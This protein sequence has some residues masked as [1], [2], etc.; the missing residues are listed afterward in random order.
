[1]E[2]SHKET[3]QGLN[4]QWKSKLDSKTKELNSQI[5]ELEQL[6]SAKIGEL[7]LKWEGIKQEAESRHSQELDA[8]VKRN[9]ADSNEKT[10][11][12]KQ[13]ADKISQLEAQLLSLGDDKSSLEENLRSALAEHDSLQS[14]MSH[15][16]SDYDKT[17]EEMKQ[18]SEQSEQ[19]I[20]SG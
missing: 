18:L 19:Q 16:Q 3:I 9:E 1:M 15:L 7:S 17:R 12:F 4:S 11:L 2:Q 6:H 13:Q 5:H 8:I 20:Q 14:K 10:I